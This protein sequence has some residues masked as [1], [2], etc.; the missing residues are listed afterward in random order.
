MSAV[1]AHACVDDVVIVVVVIDVDV[2]V[3][4]AVL[5]LVDPFTVVVVVGDDVCDAVALAVDAAAT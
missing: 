4:A 3:A 2:V 1:A 5:V